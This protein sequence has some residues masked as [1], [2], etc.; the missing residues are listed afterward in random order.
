MAVLMPTPNCF[1]A[2]L[3]DSPPVSTAATTRL[4]RSREYGLPIHAGL[5]PPQH[6]G[7]E[8]RR[9]WNPKSIQ[10][11]LI[12]LLAGQSG[13]SQLVEEPVRQREAKVHRRRD[14]RPAELG[15]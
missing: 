11:K 6:G 4:R 9:F 15:G 1:A 2:W 5:H 8:T 10:V 3:H 13:I 12:P 7:S 14:R